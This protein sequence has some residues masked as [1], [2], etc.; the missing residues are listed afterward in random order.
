MSTN[1]FSTILLIILSFF[2]SIVNSL[3][4]DTRSL[5]SVKLTAQNGEG[6]SK[7]DAQFEL[8]LRYYN[9]T[10]GAPKDY[11][12]AAYWF[13]M[14]ADRGESAAMYNLYLCYNNEGPQ[15]NPSIALA[16]LEK[17]AEAHLPIAS[18][19]LGKRYYSGDGVAR[20]YSKA[21]RYFK[22]AAF[23]DNSEGM[24][25]FAWCYAYGQ[26]VQ[27]DSIRAELWAK[28]AIS[29]GEYSAYY[30][31][32][33][34]YTNGVS[35]S[36]NPYLGA[37]WYE[38]GD[39]KRIAS[40][41]IALGRIYEKGT[42]GEVNLDKALMY[43][44]KAAE[45]GNITAIGDLARLYDDDEAATFNLEQAIYWRQ[46]QFDLGERGYAY[47]LVVDLKRAKKFSDVAK[48]YEI[49][50]EEGD[51][52]AYNGLA[53]LYAEGSLG[54]I[55]D[56]DQAL[57]IIEKAIA[58]QPDNLDYQDSKGEIMLKKGD[59]KG[60]RRIWN[61]INKKAPLYYSDWAKDHAKDT[62]LNLYMKSN[63]Q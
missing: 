38:L 14:G 13:K 30:L 43:Y 58:L 55:P 1:I 31:L 16:W 4:Q 33:N 26:G 48:V 51:S 54:G 52:G 9:G 60:A 61:A 49:L 41:Q 10:K 3:G 32:G 12:E 34:M 35:V 42:T 62:P 23:G 45:V 39:E 59:V 46:R 24:Y 22:D 53:Y 44:K 18:D 7:R 8:G 20:D 5:V 56:Y 17:A 40:C 28:R 15:N 47:H 11:K 57:L 21:I 25:Y 2:C 19:V 50:G 27:Q 36:N 63:P 37:Y 29:K 6:A